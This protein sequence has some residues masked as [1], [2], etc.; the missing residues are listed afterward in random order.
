MVNKESTEN[1]LFILKSCH[2]I[3]S[4]LKEKSF[5][6]FNIFINFESSYFFVLSLKRPYP[7][8]I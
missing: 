3:L 1:L 6:D 4:T 8:N 5:R 7:A 2:Y